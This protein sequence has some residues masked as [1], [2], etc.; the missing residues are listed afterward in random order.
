MTVTIQQRF[1]QYKRLSTSFGVL[2][3]LIALLAALNA[4]WLPGYA[5]SQLEIRLSETLQHPVTIASVEF[6]LSTLELIVHGFSVGEKADIHEPGEALFSFNRLYVGLSIESLQRRAPIITAIALTDPKLRLVRTTK[7]QLNI[8]GLLEQFRQPSNKENAGSEQSN[9]FSI[10]NM[11]IQGGHVEWID[12]HTKTEHHITEINLG[13]PIIA[14]FDSALTHWIEPHF[15]AKMNG[16]PFSLDGRL[17]LFSA[18]QEAALTFK[19]NEFD[20]TRLG[21]YMPLPDGIHLLSGFSD[22]DWLLTFTQA[23]DE[24]PDI[25]LTGHTTLRQLKIKNS[26][27]ASPYQTALKRLDVALAQVDLT[28]KKPSRI[29]LSADQMTLVREGENEPALTLAK[30]MIDHV[31]INAKTH[32]IAVGDMTLDRLSAALRRE[33]DGAIDLTRLF[34]SPDTQIPVQARIPLPARKPVYSDNKIRIAEKRTELP[35]PV[36]TSKDESSTT[37]TPWTP[38]IKRIKLNAATLRYE[39]LTLTKLTPMVVDSLDLTLDNIDLNG[40]KPLNLVLQAQVNQ[41]GNIKAAGSLAWAPLSADL[42]LHLDTVD[43]VSLQGWAGDKLTALLTRGDISFEGQIKAQG[44]PLK[45]QVGGHGSLLNFNVFN[46]ENARD[47]LRWKTLD[48]SGLNFINDPLHVDINT[49]NLNDFY[50]RLTIL[51][52]GSPNLSKIIRQDQPAQSGTTIAGTAPTDTNPNEPKEETPIHIEKIL[53]QQGSIHFNDRFIKPNYR[54]NLT[55][56]TGQ[57]GPLQPGQSGNIDIRGAVG[58]TAPLEIRGTIDPF[59]SELALDLVTHVKN[60]DLPPF[61]PYSGK[62]IGYAIE[63]GKLSADVYYQVKNGVLTADNKIFLDQ[64]TLGD[65]VDSEATVSLPLSLAITLLKNRRGEI[66]I[67]LPLQGSIHDPQFNLGD[68][69]FEAFANLIT[70]AIT[71]PFSLLGSV[72]EGGEELS[73]IQFA[74]GFADIEAEASQRLQALAQILI[75][76]PS[77]KLEISGY[78]D[79]AEDYAGLKLAT[80]QDKV[81]TQKLAEQTQKG[82]A[83]GAITEV[84]LTPEEYGEYLERVYKKEP[85][86]KPRNMIGL[87][88]SLPI[89]EMEQLMLTHI[90]INESDL[91]ALAERRAIAARN[92]LVEQGG[93]PSERIFVV[94]IHEAKEGDQKKGNRVEFILK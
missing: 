39:D 50:A 11:T 63:K 31:L 80:L 84:T 2:A 3:A 46:P 19:W 43:L 33:A 75:D 12:R 21:Q 86:E 38:Q 17:H 28:G 13:I 26:A 9:L 90:T 56:L 91:E 55:G 6:K 25:T 35:G 58:K 92:W 1:I 66:N 41:H 76:R 10:S 83:T 87:T 69:I 65:K 64:F 67:H 8:S 81:K 62:Y 37:D 82:I 79:P 30:L 20:L 14:N 74:A 47:L 42:A 29:K 4:F 85:F 94:G 5:K 89:A 40:I 15:S 27:A 71:S 49:I 77:L 16:A 51:P 24:A 32:Q 78:A 34:S 68:I 88:K 72:L 57:I 23:A 93:I 22:S 48:I 45:I 53:L 36:A 61:S 18:N 54:A 7:D 44:D 59:S 73:E 70:K 60:I 52:D